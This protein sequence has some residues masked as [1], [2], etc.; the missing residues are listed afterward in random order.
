LKPLINW[1]KL[2]RISELRELSCCLPEWNSDC[3]S[4]THVRREEEISTRRNIFDDRG[5]ILSSVR[6]VTIDL[7]TDLSVTFFSS[8]RSPQECRSLALKV[9]LI[10]HKDTYC[11][12]IVRWRSERDTITKSRWRADEN[13]NEEKGS[14]RLVGVVHR[15]RWNISR[16]GRDGSK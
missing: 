6:L 14:T 9:T 7:L 15:T 1:L 8:S 11:P 3:S 5:S 12:T 10:R 16:S 4:V 13:G 2:W